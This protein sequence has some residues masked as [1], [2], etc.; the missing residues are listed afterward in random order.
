MVKLVKD[1]LVEVSTKG[2]RQRPRERREEDTGN[3]WVK[4]RRSVQPSKG[5][6][7]AQAYL[8]LFNATVKPTV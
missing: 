3:G 6:N 1:K 7:D 4:T 5:S 8:M 2:G